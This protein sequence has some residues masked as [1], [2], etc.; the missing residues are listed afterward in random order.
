M[1][2][3]RFWV[4]RVRRG[5]VNFKVRTCGNWVTDMQV[6]LSEMPKNCSR[7]KV[8]ASRAAKPACRTTIFTSRPDRLLF[9]Y[10]ISSGFQAKGFRIP[11]RKT[12]MSGHHFY[13]SA[14]CFCISGQ[15]PACQTTIFNGR[16]P[17]LHLVPQNLNVRPPFSPVGGLFSVLLFHFHWV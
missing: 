3:F 11:G 8:V 6:L 9:Y 10:F 14:G 13:R 7:C 4:N 15:K 1:S 16:P 17:F 5:K 2:W 12:C